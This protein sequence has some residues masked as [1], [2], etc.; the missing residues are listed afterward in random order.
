MFV[1]QS[2]NRGKEMYKMNE[3]IKQK[4]TRKR[5]TEQRFVNVIPTYLDFGFF[6]SLRNKKQTIIKI[7]TSSCVCVCVCLI[8]NDI[9]S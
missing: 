2:A 6:N 4:K 3:E 9:P 5:R 1:V 7:L 8:C